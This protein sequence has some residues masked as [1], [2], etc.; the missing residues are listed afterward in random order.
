M[1]AA[2]LSA[3]ASVTGI[4]LLVHSS[5]GQNAEAF[6]ENNTSV[7]HDPKNYVVDILN[8]INLE[9]SKK[10]QLD[11]T[12][13]NARKIAFKGESAQK[14]AELENHINRTNIQFDVHLYS[15]LGS[16]EQNGTKS[17]FNPNALT[18]EKKDWKK[19]ILDGIFNYVNWILKLVAD[20][21]D[22]KIAMVRFALGSLQQSLLIAKKSQMMP[23][24]LKETKNIAYA[25]LELLKDC[26][27]DV[28]KF[29]DEE[30]KT[31]KSIPTV[32]N[33]YNRLKRYECYKIFKEALQF[34]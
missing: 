21:D 22:K 28:C 8:E 6:V 2:G 18:T 31:L 17:V 13:E 26:A 10:V 29:L 19:A 5:K 20:N 23:Q 34:E 25:K 11:K 32:D 14:I 16:I 7:N 33:E 4:G 12:S 15:L 24:Q 3:V 27:E 1:A 30:M 9:K